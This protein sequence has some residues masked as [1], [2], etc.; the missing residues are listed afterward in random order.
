MDHVEK[1]PLPKIVLFDIGNIFMTYDRVL[2]RVA[3]DFSLNFDQFS[4]FEEIFDIDANLGKIDIPDVWQKFITKYHLN[5]A[6]KYN[7]ISSWVSDYFPILPLHA[8]SV[9][10]S[11]KY[12]VGIL[13]NYYRDFFKECLSQKFI[14][15]LPFNPVIIS[16]EVGIMKPDRSIYEIAR[17]KSGFSGDE[18]FYIDDKV[19]N[20]LIPQSLG[21]QTFQFDHHQPDSS[22]AE[23]AKLLKL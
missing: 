7:L 6:A 16:A 20:L 21:W 9:K 8:L 15:D 1:L 3:Q 17:T 22:C 10:I 2:T 12:H 14:P 5:N 19:E 4:D 13:S 18:I 11:Q 23:I